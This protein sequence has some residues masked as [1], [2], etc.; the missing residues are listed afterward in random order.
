M[1]VTPPEPELDPRV[2]GQHI[3]HERQARSRTLAQVAEAVGSSPS[4]LSQVENGHREPTLRELA[5]HQSGLANTP[6]PLHRRELAYAL[7]WRERDPWAGV[8][9]EDYRRLVAQESPRR[10]PGT[11]A[12]STATPPAAARA[13]RC[14]TSSLPAAAC[15]PTPRT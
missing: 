1:S 15:A 2:V 5:T 6:R 4:H 8:S 12:C 9:G 10:A 11:G 3:K 13:H 14:R 7:G